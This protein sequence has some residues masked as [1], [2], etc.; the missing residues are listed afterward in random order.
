TLVVPIGMALGPALGSYLVEGFGYTTVFWVSGTLGLLGFLFAS[1]VRETFRGTVAQ[2][3]KHTNPLKRGIIGLPRFVKTVFQ[4]IAIS[5]LG[6]MMQSRRLSIPA[7]VLLQVGLVFGT[8][9]TFLPAY[10][11]DS[12]VGI[13]AGLFYTAV[14]VA[15]FSVRLF[16]GRAS[17]RLGRG[18]FIT[19]SLLAYIA[20]MVLLTMAHTSL[21]FIIAA[22][23]EG[24]GAGTL[25]PMMTTLVADRS[26]SQERGQAYSLCIGGFD[27]GIALGGPISGSFAP[28]LGYRGI[29]AIAAGLAILAFITFITQ[30]SKNLAHSFRFATGQEKDSYALHF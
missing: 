2:D 3:S 21:E 9:T 18:L 20:S 25:I 26:T 14:A 1:Q 24:A 17:D 7:L 5:R 30:S 12:Q 16:A 29:F 23:A 15:S 8:L 6:E 11:R 22:F 4:T 28:L 10:I 13:N 27:V 19:L